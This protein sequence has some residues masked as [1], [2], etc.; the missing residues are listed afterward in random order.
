MRQCHQPEAW[1]RPSSRGGLVEDLHDPVPGDGTV[2]GRM[3]VGEIAVHLPVGGD[4]VPGPQG[5]PA[6]N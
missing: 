2:R 4:R 1:L 3:D 6:A 5:A